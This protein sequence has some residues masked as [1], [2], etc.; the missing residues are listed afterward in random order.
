[1]SRKKSV[2]AMPGIKAKRE[3]PGILCFPGDTLGEAGHGRLAGSVGGSVLG[4]LAFPAQ[5]AD[6]EDNRPQLDF[7]GHQGQGIKKPGPQGGGHR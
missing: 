7:E 6:V 2:F 1:M 4:C 3:M 5:P